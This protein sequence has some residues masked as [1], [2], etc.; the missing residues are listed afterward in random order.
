MESH[1]DQT[2]NCKDLSIEITIKELIKISEKSN[3]G[4]IIEV[5]GNN[6]NLKN[7]L[8]E[9]CEKSNNVIIREETLEQNVLRYLI[10]IK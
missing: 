1:I 6:K 9:W 8:L 7:N 10:L 5:L 4:D 2:L 3:L